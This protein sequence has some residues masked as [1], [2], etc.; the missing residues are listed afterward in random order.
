MVCT[1]CET[2]FTEKEVKFRWHSTGV[3]VVLECS[4]CGSVLDVQI[5]S[6][7]KPRRKGEN[8]GRGF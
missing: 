8:E 7:Q 4:G 6:I 1:V 2:E 3:I 5:S